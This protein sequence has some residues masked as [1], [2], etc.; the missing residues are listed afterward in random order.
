MS[1]SPNPLRWLLL[2]LCLTAGCAS[3]D[4][5]DPYPLLGE[6]ARDPALRSAVCEIVADDLDPAG[7]AIAE[8]YRLDDDPMLRR[9]CYKWLV[10]VPMRMQG[11]WLLEGL[12]DSAEDIQQRCLLDAE[13]V[14]HWSDEVWSAM[15]HILESCRLGHTFD[16]AAYSMVRRGGADVARRIL[17]LAQRRDPGWAPCCLRALALYP[18]PGFKEVFAAA[19]QSTDLD[20]ACLA[21]R[22][23]ANLEHGTRVGP[24][25]QADMTKEEFREYW[26]QTGLRGSV[27]EVV[28]WSDLILRCRDCRVVVLGEIHA[29]VLG[30]DVQ[31]AMLREIHAAH[32]TNVVLVCERP[33][34]E[35]QRP[36]ADAAQ[37]L[38]LAV[39]FLESEELAQT[40]S[41]PARDAVARAQLAAMVASEPDKRFVV[42]Y[43]DSH[44]RSLQ[45]AVRDAG[46]TCLAISL[47]HSNGMLGS[48]IRRV[49]LRIQGLCFGFSDDTW[50]VP[51]GSYGVMLGCPALDAALAARP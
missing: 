47:L 17:D 1:C 36:V 34:Q 31:I 8:A 44:R 51:T 20:T 2:S 24:E 18:E 14:A 13:H 35:F 28:A 11:Q 25:K 10:S 49:G 29:G 19:S 50:F 5:A 23:L 16:V 37:Q 40:A 4:G 48:A 9:A 33:V 12:S 39:R 6:L 27:P 7:Q 32:G 26:R 46:A 45:A 38:G 3:T 43:G 42:C 15:W 21:R 22:A 30:R 41:A